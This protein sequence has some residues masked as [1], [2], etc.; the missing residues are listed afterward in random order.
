[1]PPAS[2]F[3]ASHSLNQEECES[4][5]ALR[6]VRN[7]PSSDSDRD[8]L[9]TELKVP[10]LPLHLWCAAV[11]WIRSIVEFL[12]PVTTSQQAIAK[13]EALRAQQVSCS[14]P[15]LAALVM[16]PLVEPYPFQVRG[17][18]RGGYQL[19]AQTNRNY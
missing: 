3:C 1:V 12:Q 16:D 2:S 9:A 7:P 19:D 11:E 17:R 10:I 15:A 5:K 6:R 14:C 13:Y 18:R 4:E 8:A